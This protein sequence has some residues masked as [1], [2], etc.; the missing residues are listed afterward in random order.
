MKFFLV[1]EEFGPLGVFHVSG[2]TDSRQ[3]PV[4][5]A[6]SAWRRFWHKLRSPDVSQLV[7]KH[8][9]TLAIDCFDHTI[10]AEY[11]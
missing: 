5:C 2:Q 9:T 1:G 6:I 8:G 11:L 4:V 7:Q 3:V 10:A